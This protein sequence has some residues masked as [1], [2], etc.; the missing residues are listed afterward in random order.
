VAASIGHMT[1][2]VEQSS[3]GSAN[4][5]AATQEQMASMEEIASSA[6]SLSKMAENMQTML[7]RFTV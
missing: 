3:S 2:I 5:S 4:I 7:N 6:S 1:E